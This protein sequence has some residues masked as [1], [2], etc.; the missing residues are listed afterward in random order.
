MFCACHSAAFAG[1]SRSLFLFQALCLQRR[2]ILLSSIL[3]C[4]VRLFFDLLLLFFFCLSVIEERSVH[5]FPKIHFAT[6]PATQQ[7]PM[8]NAQMT[9]RNLLHSVK[10]PCVLYVY[11]MASFC[12]V[13][14][15]Q[16]CP[17]DPQK[18]DFN[19]WTLLCG[20]NYCCLANRRSVN[21]ISGFF[22]RNH[23]LVSYSALP[24]NNTF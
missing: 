9:H 13:M 20:H 1:S 10:D 7:Q 14:A 3:F 21:L 5:L 23:Y 11:A 24:I 8:S 19:L 17:N 15:K 4:F 2:P 12:L 18:S 16:K 22:S 6:L